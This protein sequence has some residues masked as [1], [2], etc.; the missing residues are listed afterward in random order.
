MAVWLPDVAVTV[1]VEVP[2]GVPVVG[3]G[4]VELD[5]PPHPPIKVA[6]AMGM[7]TRQT[8]NAIRANRRRPA[9]RCVVASTVAIR[10]NI[11]STEIGSMGIPA[12]G[13]ILVAGCDCGTSKPRAV[14]VTVTAT[15][16][17]VPAVTAT[18]AVGTTQVAAVGAP[19]QVMVTLAL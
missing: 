18:A 6:A 16:A 1:I 19:E 13:C 9:G 11:A 2:A 10:S 8:D 15:A 5:P 12:G 17:G 3:G 7:S 4:V 14:V